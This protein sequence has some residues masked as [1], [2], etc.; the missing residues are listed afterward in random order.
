MKVL[1]EKDGP[2]TTI[3]LNRPERRNAVDDETARLLKQA[4]TEFD[5]NAEQAVAVLCGTGETF[6]AGYDLQSLSEGSLETPYD[7]AGD[8]PLGPSRMLLSKP[9]IC[10]VEGYAVAG[11]LELTL[12]CDMRVASETAQFG[13]FCRRWGVPLVDGGTVRLPRLIGMS[14]ALDMILTGRSVG[15]QE[16]LE[17]GLANRVV[18]AGQ[19]RVEAEKVAHEIAQ[20]PP[21]CMRTDRASAYKQ[22]DLDLPDALINEG[23]EGLVPIKQEARA[24]AA[25]FARGKGRGGDFTNI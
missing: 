3:V 1:I 24:G 22:W 17:F 12:L 19:A 23:R 25:R 15:A 8:G 21:I 4:F 9:V 6:C 7:P 5:T 14:R 18:P 20:F 13:V 11:G 16:A 10:A 2:I